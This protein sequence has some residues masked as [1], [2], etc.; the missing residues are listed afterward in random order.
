MRVTDLM[1]W[2]SEGPRMPAT[3]NGPDSIQ[4]VH[5]DIDRAFENFRR[6]FDLPFGRSFQEEVG[7]LGSIRAD[8]Q[9]TGSEIRV[10][11]ELPGMDEADIELSIDRGSLTIRG[12][13]QEEREEGQ[14]E[15]FMLRERRFGVVERTLPLPDGIDPNDATATF[16]NGVLTITIPK[17]AQA[18]QD[19]R[20][21][22]V[23]ST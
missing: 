3:G 20:R 13:K 12:V 1:P 4:A 14:G 22:P 18:Q 5:R 21:I 23:Q 2:R 19:R 7:S 17:T 10:T 15:G 16:Q 9:D 8:I 6:M 11:A